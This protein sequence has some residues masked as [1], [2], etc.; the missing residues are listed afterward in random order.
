MNILLCSWHSVSEPRLKSALGRFFDKVYVFDKP[1][2]S[3]DFDTDYIKV[4][5]DYLVQ[6]P[7]IDCCISINFIPIIAKVC[8]IH[9]IPYF[10][11]TYDS[12]S[13]SLYSDA[14]SY[15]TNYAFVI[16]K[17]LL[18]RFE[19]R[20]P[21][22]IFHLPMCCGIED[23]SDIPVSPEEKEKFSCDISFVG[24]LYTEK[25]EF[26][27]DAVSKQL[28]PYV[29]GYMDGLISAQS[30]VYGYNLFKDSLDK[31]IAEEYFSYTGLA[32]PPEYNIDIQEIVADFYL[33]YKCSAM[34]RINTLRAIGEKYQLSVY[35]NSDFSVL[36]YP[37]AV[38]HIKNC[39]TIG[40]NSEMPK[41]FKCSKINLNITT[42]TNQ[43]GIPSRIFDIMAAGGFVI[44]NYQSEIPEFFVPE[45]DIVLYDS[46]PDLLH[47]I[48]YYLSH[49]EEREAIA[50]NGHK[51]VK[52]YHTYDNRI[53]DM[54]C[55]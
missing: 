5:S 54:F 48:D 31:D 43:T 17:A 32:I 41:V 50:K 12:P 11:W 40:Y 45:E 24:S 6:N 33:G 53:M 3:I 20:N 19:K 15:D 2:N 30:N 13:L 37:T 4:L 10:S 42:R 36:N 27:Y 51:K 9:H 26:R 49:E 34:D 55:E 28:P 44:S 1:Y 22:H 18:E 46:I 23:C 47:K 8:N 52:A 29:N 38:P 16:D 21:G 35:T 14:L 25:C 39:G 7:H